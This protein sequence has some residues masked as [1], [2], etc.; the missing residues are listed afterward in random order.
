MR[1]I[2]LTLF[3]PLLLLLSS[4]HA[5]A[6][7]V[8]DALVN[9]EQGWDRYLYDEVNITYEGKWAVCQVSRYTKNVWQTA[10]AKIKFNFVKE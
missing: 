6:A 5:S 1:K 3:I 10:G 2:I 4:S 9:P 8:G 7:S